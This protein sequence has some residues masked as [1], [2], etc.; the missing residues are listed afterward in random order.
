MMGLRDGKLDLKE[1][2][3]KELRKRAVTVPVNMHVEGKQKIL[4][5]AA[6]EKLLR[7]ARIISLENCGCRTKMKKCDA[8]L[9]VC[10]CLDKYARDSIKRGDGRA[11]SVEQALDALRRSNEAG[12]VHLAFTNK[13]DERPLIICSC[14]SCCCHALLSLLRFNIPAVAE[15]EHVAFQDEEKCDGCGICVGRCQFG[16]RR[17]VDRELVFDGAKC[18]GCGL[19]V[20]ACP[21]EAISLVDR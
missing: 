11:V 21:R 6:A 12:L 17:L 13:G 7:S 9:D 1:W 3:E 2:D 16:A 19:C 14:C 10:L 8:P 5:F 18:F 20:A 15:S 4:D